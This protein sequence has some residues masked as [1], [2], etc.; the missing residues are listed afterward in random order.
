MILSGPVDWDMNSMIIVMKRGCNIETFN[1]QCPDGY[2]R[3]LFGRQLQHVTK[4]YNDRMY[5]AHMINNA[6]GINDVDATL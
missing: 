4:Q 6:G 3:K 5:G 2:D 1:N